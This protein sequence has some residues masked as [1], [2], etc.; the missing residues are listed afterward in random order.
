[1]FPICGIIIVAFNVFF[2]SLAERMDVTFMSYLFAVI[3]ILALFL[4]VLLRIPFRIALITGLAC[5]AVCAVTFAR[6]E[7]EL[8]HRVSFITGTIATLAGLDF[9]GFGLPSSAPSLGE[10]TLQAKQN[11]QAP[12]LGFTA[13]ITFATS[14]RRALESPETGGSIARSPTICRRWFWM[15]SRMAPTPS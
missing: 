11:L 5:L 4:L 3:V 14:S 9:L 2:C 6:M 12:W 8:Y 7:A 1:M 10:L 15:T 13:F